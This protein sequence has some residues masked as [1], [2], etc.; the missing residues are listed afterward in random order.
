MVRPIYYWFTVLAEPI[1]YDFCCEY[2]S[3]QRSNGVRAIDIQAAASWICSRTC[4]R[5]LNWWQTVTIKVTRALL[6]AF[7]DFG[8]LDGKP[9]SW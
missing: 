1:A 6:A 7:R 4:S 2:L 3:A 9:A 8:V 5:C